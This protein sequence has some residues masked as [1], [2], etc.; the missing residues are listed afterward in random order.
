MVTVRKGQ[1]SFVGHII[2]RDDLERLVL[3]V[4]IKGKRQRGRQRMKFLAL[5]VGFSEVE[6]LRSTV[7]R[8]GFREMV[9]NVK[10]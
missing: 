10:F 1:L 6:M 9:A 8:I 2:Q 4:T 3:E 7:D 5:A